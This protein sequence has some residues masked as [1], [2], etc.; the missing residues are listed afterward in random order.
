[1]LQLIILFRSFWYSWTLFAFA[2]VSF[3][4][5]LIH[6][7]FLL[8]PNLVP[9]LSA[10]WL[11]CVQSWAVLVL[12]FPE[13]LF[14]VSH[15]D[16]CT[17]YFYSSLRICSHLVKCFIFFNFNIGVFFVCFIWQLNPLQKYYLT[18]LLYLY[19][20]VLAEESSSYLVQLNFVT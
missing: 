18:L 15:R 1:M 14:S 5:A 9:G 4:Q 6:R 8:Y 13:K 2:L 11:K 10:S 17:K 7:Y 19:F 12:N 16:N 20:L 3:S